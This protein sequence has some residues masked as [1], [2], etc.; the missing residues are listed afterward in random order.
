MEILKKGD[1]DQIRANSQKR[2]ECGCCGCIFTAAIGE[3]R[4]ASPI[5]V[6]HDG[7]EALCECPCCGRTVYLQR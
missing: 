1:Q 7:V 3:Y 2:F 4:F 6:M 5:A